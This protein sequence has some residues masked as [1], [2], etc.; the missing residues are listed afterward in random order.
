MYQRVLLV[1]IGVQGYMEVSR[2]HP[3]VHKISA[4][5]WRRAS[6]VPPVFLRDTRRAMERLE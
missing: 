1:N 4:G 3:S 6:P 5:L 2:K